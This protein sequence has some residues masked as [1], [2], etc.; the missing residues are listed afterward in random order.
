MADGVLVVDGEGA[1]LVYNRPAEE[2]LGLSAGSL[3]VGCRVDQITTVPG[4]HAF[5]SPG[6]R[7]E[8]GE[9]R[10]VHIAPGRVLNVDVRWLPAE[11][12][13]GPTVLLL[14]HDTRD[15][16]RLQSM[17]RDFIANLFHEVRTPLA[18][19]RAC[20]ATLL[21]GALDNAERAHR[22]VEMIDQ[23]ADRL[24][25][26][27]DDLGALADLEQNPGEL[28][29]RAIDVAAAIETAVAACRDHA[30]RAGVL[31]GSSVDPAT[32]PADGD[33]DLFQQALVRLITN[34]VRYTPLGGR[35]TIS[36][37]PAA[38][39]QSGTAWVQ[40]AVVDTGVGVPAEDVER[41]GERFYRV[42][43]GRSRAQGG[44]GLGLA[45]VKHI[46]H[47]HGGTM[48][49]ASEV[50]R[51]TSVTLYWPSAKAGEQACAI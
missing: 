23:H 26:L 49:I 15:A 42:D 33:R 2:L 14:L 18:A 6:A 44:S 38:H 19:I 36:A 4:L 13:S 1:V 17:R 43:K 40:V 50:Q 30:L 22:F 16:A 46:V 35:V 5:L 3:S 34:A 41:L 27:F 9:G 20:S 47:A 31:I 10:L 11:E 29:H 39:P 51:G 48:E 21:G 24:G 8:P 25:Q 37:A 7:P 28:Q 12:G 45:L 32:P